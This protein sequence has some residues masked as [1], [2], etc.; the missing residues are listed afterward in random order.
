[1]I[2]LQ[3]DTGVERITGCYSYMIGKGTWLAALFTCS[4]ISR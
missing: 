1:M 4:L 3:H 2:A